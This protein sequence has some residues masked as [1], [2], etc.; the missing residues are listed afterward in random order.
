[1]GLVQNM[2]VDVRPSDNSI[3]R[4]RMSGSGHEQTAPKQK[5]TILPLLHLLVPNYDLQRAPD[6]R[7]TSDD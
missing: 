7:Q 5:G 4:Q 6:V 2:Q 1:M 3:R